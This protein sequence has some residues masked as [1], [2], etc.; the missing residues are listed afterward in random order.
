MN[1]KLKIGY[2]ADG[3]WS[4]LAFERIVEDQT[5][6][7][8]FIVPRT[9]TADNELLE[10]S[11]KYRIDYLYPV[12]INSAEFINIAQGYHCDLFVSMSF[13]Q[14]FREEIMNMPPLKTINCHAGQLP[15]YRGRNILN[16]ALINDEKCFGI[17]VHYV[18]GGI[19]TGDIIL[20]RTYPINDA[21]NYKSLLEVAYT[22]CANILYDAI[23]IIQSGQVNPV[24]QESIHPVGFYCGR[25][26]KGDELINWNQTSRQ[27][28]NFIR[29]VCKPGPI[30]TTF[31][32]GAE[33]KIN[34]ARLIEN[35]PNY[36]G[37]PGQILL[38]TQNGYLVKTLDSFIEVSEVYS[39]V[40]IK[41][42]DKLLS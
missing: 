3:P 28:F 13:N 25:R 23:K 40:K 19:D 38:K 4:H 39:N 20:Q 21:D 32:N 11:K 24:K 42:G 6:E 31:S 12:K 33:V 27:L 41:V 29:A 15:F 10:Y 18:D 9:D 30:A 17:T 36:I 1:R 8:A 5:I 26:G 35:A 16:W 2:F 14:I 34:K 7:I 37:T 22:E